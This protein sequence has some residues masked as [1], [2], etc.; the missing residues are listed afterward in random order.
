MWIWVLCGLIAG[1]FALLP[2]LVNSSRSSLKLLLSGKREVLIVFAH[3]D[4]ET[5]FFLPVISLLNVV[6]VPFRLLCLSTGDYDG[7]GLTRVKEFNSV[8]RYL[9]AASGDILDLPRLRDGPHLWDPS[10]VSNAVSD[11]LNSHPKIEGIITFDGYG[12]SGHPNHKS[13][14]EGVRV[15][16]TRRD[17]IKLSLVSVPLWRKYLPVLDMALIYV[18]SSFDFL[19][20]VNWK[21][22]FQSARAMQLYKSQNVWFRKLFSV[23]SRYSYVN[24]FVRI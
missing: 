20:A 19:C 5:M 22:P 11:F 9:K 15:T 24:D 12:V 7:L 13:V 4:D 18:F 14:Y 2:V 17:L 10:D 8:S 1:A 23:F 3:P 16:K 21:D 6:G